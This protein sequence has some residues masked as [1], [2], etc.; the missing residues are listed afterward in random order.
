MIGEADELFREAGATKAT[1]FSEAEML[2]LLRTLAHSDLAKT[3]AMVGDMAKVATGLRKRMM[4]HV[5][6]GRNGI[7][8][9]NNIRLAT[10]SERLLLQNDKTK[11]LFYAK[12]AERRL[13]QHQESGVTKAGGGPIVMCVDYL[14]LDAR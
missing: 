12:Q 7:E 4:R 2:Q 14:G 5:P 1:G 3:L 6:G 9:G 10:T 13:L 8:F 11:Y